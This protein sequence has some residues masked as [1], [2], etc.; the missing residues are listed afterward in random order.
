MWSIIT[1]QDRAINYFATSLLN[2]MKHLDRADI[3]ATIDNVHF[4]VLLLLCLF[5][6]KTHLLC[7]FVKTSPDASKSLCSLVH[8]ILC[9]ESDLAVNSILFRKLLYSKISS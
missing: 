2:K 3:D 1:I 7:T 6:Q 9:T 4:C 5:T 8:I